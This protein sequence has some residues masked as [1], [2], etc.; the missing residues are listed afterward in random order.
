MLFGVQLFDDKIA[1]IVQEGFFWYFDALRKNFAL[2]R[3][4]QQMVVLKSP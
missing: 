1:Q 2:I 3:S 4:F